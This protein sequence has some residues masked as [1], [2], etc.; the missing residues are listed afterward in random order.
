MSR[1]SR[2]ATDSVR[3]PPPAK[4]QPAAQ[5]AKT[6]E[7]TPG[8]A[9]APPP[10]A[11]PAASPSAARAHE[12]PSQQQTTSASAVALPPPLSPAPAGAHTGF[13]AAVP[14]QRHHVEEH[15]T[16]KRLAILS[17]TALGVVYGDIGTSPLYAMQQAF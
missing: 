11:P 12:A 1:Q 16:G 3:E 4:A 8:P 9:A 2:R 17:L 13:H 6:A 7:S 5:T 10:D 14:P 15:P